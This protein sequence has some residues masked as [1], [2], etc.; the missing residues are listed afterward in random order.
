ML[1]LIYFH[2]LPKPKGSQDWTLVSLSLEHGGLA[3][4]EHKMTV[5]PM[6]HLRQWVVR[7]TREDAQ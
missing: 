2:E 5:D 4:C 6:E 7:E 1:L 3:L